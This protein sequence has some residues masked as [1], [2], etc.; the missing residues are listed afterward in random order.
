MIFQEK[1]FKFIYMKSISFVLLFVLICGFINS[2]TTSH[3]DCEFY[4]DPILKKNIYKTVEI[5]PSYKN[6]GIQ[7]FASEVID[8]VL[9]EQISIPESEAVHNNRVVIQ[10]IISEI[11]VVEDTKIL[12]KELKEYSDLDQRFLKAVKEISSSWE[13]GVCDDRKVATIIYIPIRIRFRL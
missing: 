3:L 11:G 1:S 4:Y 9:L 2:E 8:Y 7:S 13:P 10:L 12:N 6:G 5:Y